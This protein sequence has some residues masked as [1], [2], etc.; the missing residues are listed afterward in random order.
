MLERVVLQWQ[1][2]IKR[3]IHSVSA[4]IA[5]AVGGQTVWKKNVAEGRLWK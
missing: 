3:V 4:C 1:V 2:S 5:F